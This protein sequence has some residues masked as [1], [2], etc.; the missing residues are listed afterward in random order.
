MFERY[1]ED[2]RRAV[3]HA[4]REALP[5]GSIYIEPEHLLIGLLYHRRSRVNQL[6]NLTTHREEFRRQLAVPPRDFKPPRRVVDLPLSSASKHVL[7]YAAQEADLLA[8]RSIDTE[9]L[10]LGLLREPKSRVPESLASLGIDLNSARARIK[11][12]LSSGPFDQERSQPSPLKPFAAAILLVVFLV[13]TYLIVKI[14]L[15]KI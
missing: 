9:H 6:F 1:T 10:L 12:Q 14:V 2:A 15:T 3:F 4:Y 8:S 13:L 5:S 7:A 11:P